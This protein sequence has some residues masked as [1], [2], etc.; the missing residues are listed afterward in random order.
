M[1]FVHAIKQK[2]EIVWLEKLH[3]IGT[4]TTLSY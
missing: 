3:M 4:K 2:K 1:K